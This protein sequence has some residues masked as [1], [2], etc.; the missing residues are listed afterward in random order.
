MPENARIPAHG[1][2]MARSRLGYGG[3]AAAVIVA[4]LAVR[5]PGLGLPWPVAKYAG[6]V[7]WGAMVHFL[8]AVAAPRAGLCGRAA[9][10]SFIAVAVELIR[11]YRA[12][13]LDD[14]RMTA[15]GALL[16]GRVFSLWNIVAYGV[17]I[18]GG[19]AAERLAA[20]ASSRRQPA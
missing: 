10:A 2:L 18:L 5:Y 17:G 20:R 8:V 3:A 12:P 6:S 1:G 19:G 11:L 9:A 14:F 4:G 15:A 7:L 16:L 13:W